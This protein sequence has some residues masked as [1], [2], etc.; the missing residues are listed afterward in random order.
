MRVLNANGRAIRD[1][2]NFYGNHFCQSRYTV[3]IRFLMRRPSATIV[4]S[5]CHI[6][7]TRVG[8]EHPRPHLHSLPTW[9]RPSL[10]GSD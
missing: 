4:E 10:F 1:A 3:S 5:G 8:K 2:R 6:P 9:L 7:I